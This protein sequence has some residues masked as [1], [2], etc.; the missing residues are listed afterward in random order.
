M[1]RMGYMPSDF[2]P[3]LLELGDHRDLQLFADTL[4]AFARDGAACR[5]AAEG[6]VYSTDTEVMLESM[7]SGRNYGLWPDANETGLLRWTL[8]SEDAAAFA[9]E[10]AELA[11]SGAPAGSVTLECD[12]LDEVKVKVSIGE[13][14]DQF[15]EDNAR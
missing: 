2:H 7:A 10:V 12:L 13:W 1:L 3:V 8:P 11:Q 6:H 9:A 5:L 14:E 4:A 15:L